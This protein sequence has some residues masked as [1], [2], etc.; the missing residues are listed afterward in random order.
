MTSALSRFRASRSVRPK[1]R[2]CESGLKENRT[3]K[4]AQAV[5]GQGRGDGALWE[6]RVTLT[7]QGCADIKD[8]KDMAPIARL[9]QQ[10]GPLMQR[11]EIAEAEAILDR[12]LEMLDGKAG[13]PATAPATSPK[14]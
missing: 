11:Q 7:W 14:D 2:P 13:A 5:G 3:P 1:T 10:F 4:G 8:G 9:M 12:S 6:H